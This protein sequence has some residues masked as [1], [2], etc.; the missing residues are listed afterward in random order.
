MWVTLA[1]ANASAV[2]DSAWRTC[3]VRCRSRSRPAQIENRPV[4]PRA[5]TWAMERSSGSGPAHRPRARRPQSL[6]SMVCP[7][8]DLFL[9]G[10]GAQR[11]SAVLGR[12]SVPGMGFSA[13]RQDCAS[14]AGIAAMLDSPAVS[15]CQRR[16]WIPRN[17]VTKDRESGSRPITAPSP[18]A[19][20]RC[21]SRHEYGSLVFRGAKSVAEICL[22]AGW[23]WRSNLA[24]TMRLPRLVVL[25]I[26]S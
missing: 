15:A 3:G 13:K 19:Q 18:A 12:A 17:H 11:R 16:R 21:S 9:F 24:R 14:G 8:S 1:Y 6:R 4:A 23:R 7:L 10:W 22:P 25:M 2:R 20:R 26:V 5:M